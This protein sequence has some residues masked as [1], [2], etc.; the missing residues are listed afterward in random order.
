MK[1]HRYNIK[2]E[3]EKIN[4]SG[5]Q[6][7]AKS[8]NMILVHLTLENNVQWGVWHRAGVNVNQTRCFKD[9]ASQTL[10]C[11][12]ITWPLQWKTNKTTFLFQ[13]LIFYLFPSHSSLHLPSTGVEWAEVYRDRKPWVLL[14]SAGTSNH[15]GFDFDGPPGCCNS[16]WSLGVCSAGLFPSSHKEFVHL[17]IIL[18]TLEQH[19]SELHRYLWISSPPPNEYCKCI[20][21][22][23][24]LIT[25]AFL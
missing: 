5:N 13:F 1:I 20:F 19:G 12:Q 6:R 10:L 8:N 14:I 3:Y 21:L 7:I 22:M 16:V 25:F 23:T 9:W 17:C 2:T 11:A 15:L 4:I 18:L 24:L